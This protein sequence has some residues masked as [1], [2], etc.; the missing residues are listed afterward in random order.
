M[1]IALSKALETPVST[2]L[3]ETVAESKADSI[4]VICEKLERIN[5]QFAQEK[6]RRRKALHW[7]L[8]LLGTLIAAGM[9]FLMVANSPYLGWD[10]RDPELAVAGVA[11][12]AFEWFFV[13]LAPVLF[14][15]SMI[16][17][18]LTRKK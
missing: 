1:L 2:L 16:G 14:I 6:E 5:L 9:V 3:G 7:L 4:K 18:W 10:Y 12:H 17:V 8:L 15:L 13:R 11:F